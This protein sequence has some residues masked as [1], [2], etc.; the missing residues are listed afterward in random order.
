MAVCL[1]KS[2]NNYLF[3]FQRDYESILNDQKVLSEARETNLHFAKQFDQ[4]A[5]SMRAELQAEEKRRE[6][7]LAME[8]VRLH[9]CI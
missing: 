9:I 6:E 1:W 2:H 4:R 5:D 3:Y 8:R 7:G